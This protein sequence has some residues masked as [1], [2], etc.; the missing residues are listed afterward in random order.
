MGRAHQGRTVMNHIKDLRGYLA[1]L[2]AIGELQEI[3][4]EVDWNLE[5][6][7]ICRRAYETE[8]PA[9][10]FNRIKDIETGFRVLGAPAGVSRQPGLRLARVAL[11]LGLDARA[12]GQEIVLALADA[13]KRAPIPPRIVASGPCQENV[14]LGNAI[15]LF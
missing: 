11:S 9:P 14:L 6:A 2:K 1:A 3:D 8:S 7:A 10:L 13:A 12:G 15:D 4:A 5:L